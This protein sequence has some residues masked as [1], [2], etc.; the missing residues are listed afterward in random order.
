MNDQVTFFTADKRPE[1]KEYIMTALA[2]VMER[3]GLGGLALDYTTLKANKNTDVIKLGNLIIARIYD[4]PKVKYLQLPNAGYLK[5]GSDKDFI[6]IDVS[7]LREIEAYIDK[8]KYSLEYTLESL[9]KDFSCCS[10]YEQCSDAKKCIHPDKASALGCYY[11]KV[12]A[13]GKVFY[14]VNRNID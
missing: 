5:D 11:R 8:I 3:Q 4:G 14:G 1:L 9:P 7:S 12:L 10:R 13:S 6:R 2:A